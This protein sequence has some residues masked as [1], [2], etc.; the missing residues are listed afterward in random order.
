MKISD[1]KSDFNAGFSVALV[2]LPLS[3]GI[4]LASGA[5]ASAGLIAAIVGGIIGSWLGGGHLNINGPAA[6]LIVIVLE[7]ILSLGQGDMMRGFQGMLAASVVAG[8]MQVIFGCMKLG[9]KG[10]AFPVS[11][12]HGMMAAIGLIII[13]KQVHILLGYAPHAKSPVMLFAEIPSA[14]MNLQPK[15][16]LVGGLS[17]LFLV[18][19]SKF[20]NPI[21]KKI[22]G[23]LMAVLLGSTLAAFLGLEGKALLNVPSDLSTWI[24][25]PDFSVMQSFAGWR[26]AI[27]IALVASLETTLSSSAVDKLDTLKR[28]TDLDRDLVSK[29]ICN[30][31][32]GALGGLPMI[33]EIVR[34]SAN[35][36]Y[37]AK[38]KASNFFHGAVILAAVITLPFALNVVPLASLAA[39]LIMV[40]SRL[41]S[42]AHLLHA[43][44]IGWDHLSGFV[45][46]LVVTLAVDLLVGI[47]AGAMTQ[48]AVEMM[49]GLKFKNLVTPG[50]NKTES[51]SETVNFEI[52]SALTF[53]NFLKVQEG[54]RSCLDERKNVHLEFNQ[55]G[56]IDHN[57]MEAISD[58]QRSF[59]DKNLSLTYHLSDKH[60][61]LGTDSLSAKKK[62]A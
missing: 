41:G 23:P 25:F 21:A 24:I 12:I 37:G 61:S 38:T 10:S 59:N 22:P 49:L 30:I 19:W 40:G 42:P 17:L 33:S 28:K 15:I 43:K 31:L 51:G 57:V 1:Y 62:T 47:F 14:V 20:K 55:C 36:S 52:F 32:S 48:I 58:F 27:A 46:T 60:S 26:A 9:R 56:Y 8:A 4:A 13:A 45:V 39:I 44:K 35:I 6:G 50:F 5:P 11:V 2:A 7:A 34:S 18:G 3:I 54:I 16:F 29:G 53:S